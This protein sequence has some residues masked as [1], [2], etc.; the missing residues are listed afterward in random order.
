MAKVQAYVAAPSADAEAV[1]GLHSDVPQV[2]RKRAH[3]VRHAQGG[4]GRD[5]VHHVGQPAGAVRVRKSHHW[6]A[7]LQAT[8]AL[9]PTLLHVS[10]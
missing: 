2:P 3:A 8:H 9:S 4:W 5:P 1:K 6:H 10:A 7:V